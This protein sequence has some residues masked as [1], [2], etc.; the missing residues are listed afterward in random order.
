M[1]IFS[2]KYKT[3]VGSSAS[4]L[5]EDAMV[6]DSVLSGTLKSILKDVDLAQTVISDLSKSI[7]ARARSMYAYGR[8]D[9]VFGTPEAVTYT[10]AVGTAEI[11]AILQAM[12]PGATIA[13]DY[14]HLGAPNILHIGWVKLV[15]EHGYNPQTNKLGALTATVGR[16]VYLDDL[17]VVL[18]QAT[19]NLYSQTSTAQW[20]TPPKSNYSPSRGI[21]AGAPGLSG[22]VRFTD[23]QTS[24]TATEDVARADYAWLDAAG[25]LHTD[26]F[27]I[28]N[29]TFDEAADYFQV[30]YTVSGAQHYWSYLAGSGGYPELDA[31]SSSG[32][33]GDA[34][35][36]FF[37]Y[38]HFRSNKQPMSLDPFSTEYKHSV[39]MAKK[40]GLDYDQLHAA[41]H[42]NPGIN[43]IAQSY[44]GM[45][46]PALSDDPLDKRYLF[47][48]FDRV[49]DAGLGIPA[50]SFK[51]MVRFG[52]E[53]TPR[54]AILFQDKKVKHS[55][56]TTGIN[57][58]LVAGTAG[59]V[60][61]YT[62]GFNATTSLQAAH[63]YFRR[64]LSSAV[65]EELLVYDLEMRYFIQDGYSAVGDESDAE[66]LIP[67]DYAITSSFPLK[68]QERLYARSLR[69]ISNSSVT[70]EVKWYQQGWFV[71]V[72]QVVAVVLAFWDGGFTASLVSAISAGVVA[73]IQLIVTTILVNMAIA[74]A[75]QLFAQL[76]GADFAI[77]LAVVAA[78]YGAS[79]ALESG[80]KV[81][82][83]TL[84]Q[85]LSVATGLI[86]GAAKVVM[87]DLLELGDDF[88][89]F[90]DEAKEQMKLLDET[91]A[92]LESSIRLNPLVIFGETP[93][94]YYNRTVHSGNIGTIG[95]QAIESYV[96]MALTLPTLSDSFGG[97]QDEV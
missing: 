75:F 85:M 73:V 9:Y 30:G 16:D 61:S 15:Q 42:E 62:N 69:I 12:H 27:T 17:V 57:R 38:I 32:A 37:P 46:V 70:V 39:K 13:L 87:D 60:G 3:Y 84:T 63:H 1:G 43:D 52:G 45:F 29:S 18:P 50:P 28:S 33:P 51:L 94:N 24:P 47:E 79:Q 97:T 14:L 96:D 20:G 6:P 22:L 49:F 8:R 48:F 58:R 40:L 67:V 4:R 90:K 88:R 44:L 92:L 93:E 34:V 41:I 59:D 21:L 2:S 11:T 81:A 53:V 72:L 36:S 76:V 86:N 10:S 55:L 64:Q 77:L 56:S 35:G 25:V 91:K 66:L 71:A 7:G 89:A 74:Y 80:L 68:L 83:P 78:A 95:Y 82:M 23:V 54:A 5:I 26:S 19:F 31:L 65:Y